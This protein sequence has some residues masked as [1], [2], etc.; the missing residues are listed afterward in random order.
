MGLFPPIRAVGG[1]GGGRPLKNAAGSLKTATLTL[2]AAQL[3]AAQATAGGYQI[4]PAVAGSLLVPTFFS[5]NEDRNLGWTSTPTF[6]LVHASDNSIVNGCTIGMQAGVNTNVQSMRWI[7][8]PA[9]TQQNLTT[10]LYGGIAWNVK[11]NAALTGAGSYNKN[12][13]F[14]VVY[15][16]VPLI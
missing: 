14:T 13:R 8:P 10:T 16:E 9:A 5:W 12:P 6:Q 2:T 4:V 7:T 1:F 3:Q 15:Y 11:L